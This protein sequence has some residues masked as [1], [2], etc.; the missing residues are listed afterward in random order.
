MAACLA[1][2]HPGMTDGAIAQGIALGQLP[3]RFE[4]VS[5]N[6]T[7]ILDVAH[8]PESVANLVAGIAR[9]YPGRRTA[10]VAGFLADKPALTMLAKMQAVSDKVL[11]APVQDSRSFS[12]ANLDVPGAEKY[13]SI[14]AAMSEA[15]A[16]ADVICVT[17]SFAAVR[18]ARMLLSKGK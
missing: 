16:N 15:A 5:G 2:F 7:Y 17:G 9:K 10:F 6:P 18:E 11:F 13:S 14:G 4:I 12:A 1:C 3:G 8:T